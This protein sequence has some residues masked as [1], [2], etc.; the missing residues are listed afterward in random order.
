MIL[1]FILLNLIL[2]TYVA[3][4]LKLEWDALSHWLQKAQV[5]FRMEIMEILR[6]FH[7]HIIR[8]LVAFYGVSFGRIVF[9]NWST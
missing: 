3:L 9:Y 6:M 8:I 5:F 2:F 7:F 1:I 4:N